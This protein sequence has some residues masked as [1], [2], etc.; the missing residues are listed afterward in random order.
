[1][2]SLSEE[3]HDVVHPSRHPSKNQAR[4]SASAVRAIWHS[5]LHVYKNTNARLMVEWVSRVSQ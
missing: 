2:P 3:E 4:S 5:S 1:M